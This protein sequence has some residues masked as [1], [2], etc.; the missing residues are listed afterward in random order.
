MKK[1]ILNYYYFFISPLLILLLYYWLNY[2]GT[3]FPHQDYMTA[4]WWYAGRLEFVYDILTNNFFSVIN[5][6][7]SLGSDIRSDIKYINFFDIAL[8]FIPFFGLF[9]AIMIKCFIYVLV[10][11]YA[12]FKFFRLYTSSLRLCFLISALTSCG[13]LFFSDGFYTTTISYLL[14]PAVVYFC[15]IYL[16]NN[17]FKNLIFL[18]LF[19]IFFLSNIDFNFI[20]IVPII[21]LW[22]LNGNIKNIFHNKFLII[23]LL[24]FINS[25]ILNINLIY[26]HITEF[27]SYDKNIFALSDLKFIHLLVG[28]LSTF[29]F[30]DVWGPVTF[31][32]MPILV[33][34]FLSFEKDK[35]A[36]LNIF[37]VF[38]LSIFFYFL[39]IFSFLKMPSIVRYHLSV[40][41]ILIFFSLCISYIKIY[42]NFHSNS[43]FNFKNKYLIL[44]IIGIFILML[45]FGYNKVYSIICFFLYL[46][47]ILIFIFWNNF[48][49]RRVVFYTVPIISMFI[50]FGYSGGFPKKSFRIVDREHAKEYNYILPRCILSETG[51][52][53]FIVVANNPYFASRGVAGRHDL[54]IPLNESRSFGEKTNSRTFFQWRHSEHKMISNFNESFNASKNF[55]VKRN[56]SPNVNYYYPDPTSVNNK[57]FNSLKRNNINY[58]V[59]LNYELKDKFWIKIK[60]CTPKNKLNT[61]NIL[62]EP[63]IGFASRFSD[64]VYLY[65]NKNKINN[66]VNFSY[67]LSE[68]QIAVKKTFKGHVIHVPS[69]FYKELYIKN[70][71]NFYI[72]R[73]DDGFINLI[74]KI[75][76][77][78]QLITISSKTIWMFIPS[79]FIIFSFLI[80]FV[81]KIFKK[82]L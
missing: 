55:N 73:S 21:I 14:I 74:S 25:L 66:D 19:I 40:A 50:Y 12:T 75:E 30:P 7:E 33:F 63:Y 82:K 36:F 42:K 48:F 13:I 27:A 31:F 71:N 47:L 1:K 45:Y 26:F 57:F 28:S 81:I 49:F 9:N 18:N 37:Y 41:G 8:F 24:F 11:Y 72:S 3:R 58:I 34:F 69:I 6:S 16:I 38:F 60:D 61:Y 62:V 59:T 77:E 44:F 35:Y 68:M 15:Q 10:A 22:I 20:F 5:F 64:S 23:I 80:I 51:N 79:I 53:D 32:Y 17:N 54:L 2:P 29:F 43:F 56:D 4:D 76:G 39:T 78:N 46:L 70:N 67:S 52:N 65:Y